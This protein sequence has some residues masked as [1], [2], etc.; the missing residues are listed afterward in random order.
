MR[1]GLHRRH[2]FTLIELLVVI[3]IIAILAAI[4]LPVFA[5]ARAKARKTQCLSNLKQLGLGVTMYEQDYDE[6]M[7]PWGYGDTSKH[8][9]GTNNVVDG[10]YSWDT[11]VNPYLR[12][13]QILFCTDNHFGKGL[14]SY[15][16]ARYAFTSCLASESNRF[17]VVTTGSMPDPSSTI[18][19]F[20]KGAQL[21]G[22]S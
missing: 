18:M 13:Q 2:G 4:L 11:L 14:R 10:F 16:A 8:D 21:P 1:T 3:A 17:F 12:N 5:R 19:L 15:A 7:P 22:M 9:D 6:V 20:D